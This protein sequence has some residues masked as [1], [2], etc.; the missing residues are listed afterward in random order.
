[1][2]KDQYTIQEITIER[3][4]GFTAGAFPHIKEFSPSLNVIWGPNGI[5]K[6]TLA[7]AL[8]SLVWDQ[9]RFKSIRA[10]GL[11][12]HD[13]TLYRAKRDSSS[14][15]Q[16]R[17]QDNASLS[18]KGR[19]DELS[20]M[21]WF[22]LRDLLQAT[23][24]GEQFYSEIY[25][26]MRGG[27]DID[28][29]KKDSN[30]ISSFSQR[31]VQQYRIASQAKKDLENLLKKQQEVLSLSSTIE[32]L[33]QRV[34][35]LPHL[36]EQQL[37][38]RQAISL[39]K[40]LANIEEYDKLLKAFDPRM[41]KIFPHSAE[42]GKNLLETRDTH[43][44][45]FEKLQGDITTF[46]KRQKDLQ[47]DP[48]RDLIDQ[49]VELE[50][51]LQSIEEH[52]RR[53]EQVESELSGSLSALTKWEEEHS[54]LVSELP[55]KHQLQAALAK[56]RRMA[57]QSEPLRLKLHLH[58]LLV[59]ELGEKQ[60]LTHNQEDLQ[61]I[62]TRIIDVLQ[63]LIHKQE[64]T[65]VVGPTLISII[66]TLGMSILSIVVHP[67]FSIVSIGPIIYLLIL[68]TK[69][70]K[71]KTTASTRTVE[72]EIKRLQKSLT[73]LT[74]SEDQ[75]ITVE[76]LAKILSTVERDLQ[77]NDLLIKRNSD[78]DDAQSDLLRSKE[79]YQRWYDQ[80]KEALEDL[81][82][83]FTDTSLDSSSFFHFTPHLLTWLD[84]KVAVTTNQ[85]KQKSIVDSLEQLYTQLSSLIGDTYDNPKVL[86]LAAKTVIEKIH[87]WGVLQQQIYDL[88]EELERERGWCESS[89]QKFS[90]YMSG[91]NLTE[92]DLDTLVNLG[93][94][95]TQ[96]SEYTQIRSTYQQEYNV[97]ADEYPASL[98]LS[99]KHTA[100]ELEFMAQEIRT[101]LESMQ[102]IQN[103]LNDH[104]VRYGQY[105]SGSALA[106]AE[107]AY[108][109]ALQE[110]EAFREEQVVSR[111]VD[112]LGTYIHQKS[113]AAFTPRVL[114]SSSRWF[115]RITKNLYTLKVDQDGFYAFD[116]TKKENIK[117]DHLS[118][119]TRVQLL[120]AVRMGFIAIQE[121]SSG[122]RFPLFM[123]ELL[124]NSDDVRALEIIN[125]MHEIA[126]TRQVF[127]FTAQA[128]EVE[129]IKMYGNNVK[130]ISLEQLF[131]QQ[132]TLITPLVMPTP[133]HQ[134]DMVYDENY[135]TYGQALK[136]HKAELFEQI[137]QLHSWYLFEKSSEL[138]AH[139]K[140]GH[141]Q[142]GQLDRN[143]EHIHSLITLLTTAQHQAQV[144]RVKSLYMSDIEDSEL[145]LNTKAKYWTQIQEVVEST[146]SG[147][148]LVSALKDG[149]VK[150]LSEIQRETMID[151]LIENQ[152]YTESEP[153]SVD[154]ILSTIK[155]V[156]KE[157]QEYR[158]AQRYLHH[159]C[160]S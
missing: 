138:S 18:L 62:K 17:L 84:L 97:L 51:L 108:R 19:S 105:I 155:D 68:L 16:I 60:K 63:V 43:K 158:I 128:D 117:L 156:S 159:V 22:S 91:F 143:D 126:Q 121:E 125:V 34:S 124:A 45:Q 67:A 54:W 27:I 82:M 122:V 118:D 7:R 72:E 71:G 40:G 15:Q 59:R 102:E 104:Q 136:V 79:E 109:T 9:Q 95:H 32:K 57:L 4:K 75:D 141:T 14:L 119:G 55:Q 61:E 37:N 151:F 83:T 78:I 50:T 133:I 127:Y 81:N 130:E 101:E 154:Q 137:E 11:I 85:A 35:D 23:E 48:Q 58:E 120:F 110:L 106:Q 24:Q 66:T 76:S 132:K 115:E 5:G 25:K 53:L 31:G 147:S 92:K 38:I 131:T 47:L 142:L 90:E 80:Y 148:S 77:A 39:R 73:S 152:F 1:M 99:K 30:A 98:A 20:S 26:E 114:E 139:L 88:E 89:E 160:N 111:I 157:S 12:E 10:T 150:N 112:Y 70:R 13:N 65:S 116:N 42:H 140:Q 123:D 21:Y 113:D 86:V 46:Q 144:G 149:K 96:W 100:D 103:E 49:Q 3:S 36:Q 28:K 64:S 69:A 52:T 93:T 94:Y 107:K 8:R 134:Q 74:H 129:K 146:H 87:N 145:E 135:E 56:L 153:L 41:E 29:A 2:S 33:K 44:R 6:T